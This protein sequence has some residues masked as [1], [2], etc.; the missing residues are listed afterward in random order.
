MNGSLENRSSMFLTLPMEISG[1]FTNKG[2]IYSSIV[3]AEGSFSISDGAV[4]EGIDNIEPWP[5]G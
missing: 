1:T 4:V 2:R 5:E 3:P